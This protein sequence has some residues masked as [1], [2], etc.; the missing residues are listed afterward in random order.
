M[1]GVIIIGSTSVN[2]VKCRISKI[3]SGHRISCLV[4]ISHTLFNLVPRALPV[5]P[6]KDTVFS[7]LMVRYPSKAKAKDESD[8]LSKKEAR[9]MD[10]VVSITIR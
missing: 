8:R 9:F 1:N 6:T 2:N 3:G 7:N 4:R 5:T 10:A